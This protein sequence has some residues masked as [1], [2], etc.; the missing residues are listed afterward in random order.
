M[1]FLLA[2]PAVAALVFFVVCFHA[3]HA[4][5]LLVPQAVAV[6]TQAAIL[7]VA[8]AATQVVDLLAP[9]PLPSEFGFPTS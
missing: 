3:V 7:V 2:A 4:V 8:V 9:L 1:K 6:V 5:L